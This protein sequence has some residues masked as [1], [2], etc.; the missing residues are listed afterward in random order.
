MSLLPTLA[1]SH[2]AIFN[3]SKTKRVGIP[4][5]SDRV[6]LCLSEI[7]S[8]I[9]LFQYLQH[10]SQHVQRLTALEDIRTVQYISNEISSK[11]ISIDESALIGR[12][13]EQQNDVSERNPGSNT[14]AKYSHSQKNRTSKLLKHI[15]PVRDELTHEITWTLRW[16]SWLTTNQGFETSV[17]PTVWRSVESSALDALS[18]YRVKE[19]H[20]FAL[21]MDTW[22]SHSM[23][24]KLRSCFQM[25]EWHWKSPDWNWYYVNISYHMTLLWYHHISFPWI[26][27]KF[28]SF[29]ATDG[30][31]FKNLH[32]ESWV[33]DMSP[34]H[35]TSLQWS[36]H[37]MLKR[38]WELRACDGWLNIEVAPKKPSRA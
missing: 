13:E 29:I 10:S 23:G 33:P 4:S 2:D 7:Y 24:Q 25:F 27:H 26:W 17:L 18:I 21:D 36:P 1:L 6:P 37:W 34:C 38:P 28:R 16:L 35:P 12:L 30:A 11:G 8:N 15:G 14:R 5:T 9:M 22:T 20:V 31:D 19:R 32:T 3:D